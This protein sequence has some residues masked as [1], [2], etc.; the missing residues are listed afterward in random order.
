MA[1]LGLACWFAPDY[2][3]VIA[4]DW[5]KHCVKQLV[6]VMGVLLFTGYMI[7]VMTWFVYQTIALTQS[8]GVL[9]PVCLS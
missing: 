3:A 4:Q 9:F 1:N 8:E 6:F 2:V 7:T 5:H